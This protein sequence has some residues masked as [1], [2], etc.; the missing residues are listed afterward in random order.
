MAKTNTSET[1]QTKTRTLKKVSAAQIKLADKP[2]GFE[3]E[4][5]FVGIN[6]STYVDSNG[7][8]K[9]LHTMI[10]EN[11]SGERT[12]FLADAGLRGALNDA[13]VVKGDWFKAVKG[14]KENIGKGRTMNVWDIFQYA[15]EN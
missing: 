1:T 14:E 10:I 2:V 3:L 5:R 13:M 9:M 7:E 11:E 15:D 6:Q 4:G 12:K 8:E